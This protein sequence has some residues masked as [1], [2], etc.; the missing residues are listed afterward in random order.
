MLR[1][2]MLL[3]AVG[4]A[5]ALA[6]SPARAQLSLPWYTIDGGGGT[7]TLSGA[8][9]QPDAGGPMTGGSFSLTGG[10]WAG[11]VAAPSCPLDENVDGSV[12][13]DDP[14]DFTVP[15]VPGPGGYAIPCPEDASPYDQGY[16]AA[17][18]AD[19]SGQCNPPF[20][21]NLGDFITAYFQG[22]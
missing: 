4:S 22:C 18:T 21:D 12:N 3:I 6:A 2:N 15:H 8:I 14:G 13:P 9:C 17:S 7:F 1:T 5:P 19:L 16:K 10:F 20:P 11:H